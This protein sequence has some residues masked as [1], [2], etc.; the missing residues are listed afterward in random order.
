MKT[1]IESHIEAPQTWKKYHPDMCQRCLALCC[2][3]PVEATAQDLVRMDFLTDFDIECGEKHYLKLLKN[4]K[5]IKS[6]SR[7][8][9]KFTLAHRPNGSCLFLE[10]SR[11]TIYQKRPETCRNHPEIGPRPGFCAYKEKN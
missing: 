1:T 4:H 8:T 7:P 5:G 6:Y 11:C 9:G 10:N 3:L 2:H